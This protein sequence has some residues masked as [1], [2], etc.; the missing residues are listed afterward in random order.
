MHCFPVLSH[1]HL[2]LYCYIIY[3]LPLKFSV[4]NTVIIGSCVSLSLVW[5]S[6]TQRANARAPAPYKRDFE[7]KLRNFYRK[8]ETKGYGQGP[9]KVKYGDTYMSRQHWKIHWSVDQKVNLNYRQ[10]SKCFVLYMMFAKNN[11]TCGCSVQLQYMLSV[12]L[13]ATVCFNM[14]TFPLL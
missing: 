3:S 12:C 13:L 10:Q 6:G 7:A 4:V 14:N 8:L 11:S 2:T 1:L 5:I 9:G